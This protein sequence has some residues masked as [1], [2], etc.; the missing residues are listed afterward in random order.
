MWWSPKPFR[1]L[2]QHHDVAEL[3]VWISLLVMFGVVVI[4]ATFGVEPIAG[5]LVAFVLREECARG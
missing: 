4:A 1:R 3:G 2:T 5:A